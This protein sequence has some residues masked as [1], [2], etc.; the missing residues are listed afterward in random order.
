[1]SAPASNSFRLPS[2]KDFSDYAAN[3][4]DLLGLPLQ[5][6]QDW[7][8]RLY[9]YA[10]LHEL[11]KAHAAKGAFGPFAGEE[12][13]LSDSFASHI[14]AR[15]QRLDNAVPELLTQ[16]TRAALLC[17][18]VKYM[19]LFLRPKR[20]RAR[21]KRVLFAVKAL[22]RFGIP[23]RDIPEMLA[24]L[25]FTTSDYCRPAPAYPQN[26]EH[27][28][29]LGGLPFNVEDMYW[30]FFRSNT[31][32]LCEQLTGGQKNT[33]IAEQW[34][35][36][37]DSPAI[38]TLLEDSDA[39]ARWLAHV[40]AQAKRFL[41]AGDA[42]SELIARANEK[43]LLAFLA[44][45]N[46][47]SAKVNS[48]LKAI[49][50]IVRTAR[51]W[52]R[53][54]RAA[55]LASYRKHSVPVTLVQTEDEFRM[56][57][58]PKFAG[59]RI[60]CSILLRTDFGKHD[61]EL[62]YCHS[63]SVNYSL[64]H[65]ATEHRTPFAVGRGHLLIPRKGDAQPDE[66]VIREEIEWTAFAPY[67]S[68]L[69]SYWQ[70]AHPEAKYGMVVER[71]RPAV[72]LID[73]ATAEGFA[74]NDWTEDLLT[75]F[76]AELTSFAARR[77]SPVWAAPRHTG[78]FAPP[79]GF[80]VTRKASMTETP[81]APTSSAELPNFAAAVISLPGHVPFDTVILAEPASQLA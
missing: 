61:E 12:E 11:R 38:E 2:F 25:R 62:I 7:L 22:E 29:P 16:G 49:P 70:G 10:S 27:G 54:R 74:L 9:G 5:S 3:A 43:A 36:E 6:C 64:V 42:S 15:Q 75:I 45:P 31:P 47:E 77:R 26:P 66:S 69:Q 52:E 21:A 18:A 63:F 39:N 67:T 76:K 35:Y 81:E 13:G 73:L 51:E 80:F 46:E 56:L 58:D 60:E 41:P 48:V 79:A 8:A 17:P 55:W 53:E 19:G 23:L 71:S 68:D 50:D 1:M 44:N 65:M 72:A 32:Y 34:G 57:T 40:K 14:A 20:H 78:A 4:A 24:E 37:E 30:E 59:H 28:Q 33:F